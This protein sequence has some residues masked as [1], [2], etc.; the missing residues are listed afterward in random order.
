[1][2]SAMQKVPNNSVA[3][4]KMVKL[5]IASLPFVDECPSCNNDFAKIIV[6]SSSSLSKVVFET[7]LDSDC[8]IARGTMR[9]YEDNLQEQI[10]FLVDRSQP[11][12]QP[13]KARF[14]KTDSRFSAASGVGERKC[15]VQQSGIHFCT[16]LFH[17]SILGSLI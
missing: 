7:T 9:Y 16:V 12:K 17:K 6:V 2:I 10:S 1:M 8:D 15:N 13:S 11:T 3:T 4:I 14:L 5:L